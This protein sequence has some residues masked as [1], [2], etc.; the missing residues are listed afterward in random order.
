MENCDPDVVGICES[1][2]NSDV[3]DSELYVDGHDLFRLD[4]QGARGGG[5]LLY[6]RSTLQAVEFFPTAKRLEVW[7]EK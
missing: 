7:R 3:F 4:R 6:T 5:V 1:W 2:A